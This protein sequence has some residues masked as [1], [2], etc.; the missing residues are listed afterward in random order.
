[1]VHSSTL[2]AE[3]LNRYFHES[4]SF[5]TGLEISI[6]D[7]G[8]DFA[9]ASMPLSPQHR[10]GLGNAHGGAIYTL[11]DMAFAAAAHASGTFFVTSQSS[12]SYLEPGRLGPL[13]AEAKKIRV[14]KTLGT[15]DVRV[16][17]SDGVLVAIATMTGYNTHIPIQTVIVDTEKV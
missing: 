12:I 6:V 15:F 16:Y 11:V 13:R 7:V 5:A 4:D 2:D 8:E 9:V 1:M 14:G 17:D 10:N 3:A